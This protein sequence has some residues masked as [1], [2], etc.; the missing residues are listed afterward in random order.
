MTGRKE[1]MRE[2]EQMDE[3]HYLKT[4][5]EYRMMNRRCNEG[6]KQEPRKI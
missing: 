2:M 1:R 3:M 4:V 5:V 6:Y